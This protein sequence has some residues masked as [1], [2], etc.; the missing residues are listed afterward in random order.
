MRSQ[1]YGTKD[2]KYNPT[3]D[4][5]LQGEFWDI[6]LKESE[7]VPNYEFD[8]GV[9]MRSWLYQMFTLKLEQKTKITRNPVGKSPR[10]QRQRLQRSG[11]Q[12]GLKVRWRIATAAVVVC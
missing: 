7:E 6:E 10:R 2:A 4:A 11:Y 1:T 5:E 12:P 9:Y 8:I 3:D